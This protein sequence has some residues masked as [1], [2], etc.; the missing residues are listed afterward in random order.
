METRHGVQQKSHMAMHKPK[1]KSLYGDTRQHP[2]VV[3]SSQVEA[4]RCQGQRDASSL[5]I[6]FQIN[7]REPTDEDQKKRY[8][9]H[10]ADQK[11]KRGALP[12]QK[13]KSYSTS[14]RRETQ[15]PTSQLQGEFEPEREP[16]KR[17]S[18]KGFRNREGDS[19]R[20]ANPQDWKTSTSLP[21]NVF[22][23]ETNQFKSRLFENDL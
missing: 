12:K 21:S 15:N 2:T 14:Q 20:E 5:R 3:F 7:I 8:C 4:R 22:P 18:K 19:N 11:K 9:Q 16:K 17:R 6:T 23:L 13:E 10:A 1:R